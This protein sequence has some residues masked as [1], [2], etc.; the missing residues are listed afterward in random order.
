MTRLA[1]FCSR[2]PSSTYLNDFPIFF[3]AGSMG[4]ETQVYIFDRTAGQ[5]W[6]SP[7]PVWRKFD[8]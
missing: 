2:L 1:V 5:L 8:K 3:R 4:T 7:F 6:R